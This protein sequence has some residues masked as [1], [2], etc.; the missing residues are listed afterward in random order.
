MI[1]QSIS[2][3]KQEAILSAA[4]GLFIEYGFHGT[5]TSKIAREAGVAHGTLFHYFKTKDELIVTLYNS[6]QE[7]FTVYLSEQTKPST[8]V[9]DRFKDLFY[10]S[11]QWAVD[12]KYEFYFTQQFRHSPYFKQLGA[13]PILQPS[14]FQSLYIEAIKDNLFKP[15]TVGLIS[16]LCVNQIIGTYEYLIQSDLSVE[17]QKETINE[18]A[19]L[20]WAMFVKSEIL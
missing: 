15:L 7:G 6:I 3:D 11:V 18:I 17:K 10:H 13:E 16:S 1:T 5:P 8:S 14:L 4:L 20:T 9:V 19:E 12:Y 2:F